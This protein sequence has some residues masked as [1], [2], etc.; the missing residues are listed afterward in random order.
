M[1]DHDLERRLAD[2]KELIGLWRTFHNFFALAVKGGAGITSEREAQFLRLKSR[3]AM[4]HDPLMDSLTHDQAIGQHVLSL[5]ERSIT[6]KH[7]HKLSTA[8]IK[9]ME[10]EWH[11]A[12]LLLSE[13]VGTMEEQQEVLAAVNPTTY[14]LKK[15]QQNLA[16]NIKAFF[17]SIYFKLILVFGGIPIALILLNQAWPLENLKNYK[18]TKGFYY[19]GQNLYRIIDATLPYDRVEDIPRK[20]SERPEN[21]ESVASKFDKNSAAMLLYGSELY[22]IL[23]GANVSFKEEAYEIRENH[24]KIPL[25]ILF[26]LIE[27]RDRNAQAEDIVN[28]YVNW[29]NS[30]VGIQRAALEGL[31][32]VFRKNNVA[33]VIQSPKKDARL[34]IKEMEFGVLD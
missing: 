32:T 7:L 15:F 27:G 33:I 10:I 25:Y 11:E 5:V 22:N 2:C 24:R 8:E 13:V 26:F 4:L 21:L 17:S 9:K 12:Y 18:L 20:T 29:K 14:R 31:Y 34:T 30:H 28:K 3:I 6:L 23:R 19:K 16:F 1:I